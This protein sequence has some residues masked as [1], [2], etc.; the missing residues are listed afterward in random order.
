MELD[1]LHLRPGWNAWNTLLNEYGTVLVKEIPVF[2]R[3][4]HYFGLYWNRY[5]NIENPSMP[6]DRARLVTPGTG[7]ER[8]EHHAERIWDG[9]SRIWC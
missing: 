9:F 2:G 6:S 5:E 4:I 3:K 8:L 7:L 1:W